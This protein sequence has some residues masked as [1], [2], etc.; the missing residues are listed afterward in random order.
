MRVQDAAKLALWRPREREELPVNTEPLLPVQSQPLPSAPPPNPT[1]SPAHQP[2][3]PGA[4]AVHED[5]QGQGGGAEHEG[6]DGEAQVEH[7]F[8]AVAAQPLALLIPG[9]VGG[10]C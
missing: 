6:A 8:L 3:G 7:L 1:T 9:G 2:R 4:E 10:V 5:P